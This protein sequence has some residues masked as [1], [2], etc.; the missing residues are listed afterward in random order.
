MDQQ[1]SFG[2]APEST[3]GIYIH[4]P[5]CVHRCSYCAFVSCVGADLQMPYYKALLNE[6]E[7]AGRV[8]AGTVDSV[9]IGGGTPSCAPRGV[10]GGILDALRASFKFSPTAEITLEANPD[11][12]TLDAVAEWRNAD[13]NRLSIGLQSIQA[14]HLF[15]LGRIHTLRD[16]EKAY[17]LAHDS[18]FQ[19]INVDLMYGLP[20]QTAGEWRQTIRYIRSLE[21]EHV[22]CYALSLEEGTSLYEKVMSGALTVPDD[23]LEAKMYTQ[24]AHMLKTAGYNHYEISNFA[25]SGSECR[26]NIK[27]WS[28]DNY[29]GIGAA[30]H[31]L[32]GLLRFANT[33]SVTDY[34]REYENGGLHY[35]G[36]EFV[37]AQERENEFVMLKTRLAEGFTEDEYRYAF[38]RPFR[39]VHAQGLERCLSEGLLEEKNGRI[40]PTQRGFL[41]QN[42]LALNLMTG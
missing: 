7:A 10:V 35:T 39:E 26:H 38:G 28:L 5:F 9:F 31:S 20:S 18:G 1:D 40:Q 27:Y 23:T 4:W 13:V 15:R 6:I 30:A 25:R 34:V 24:A 17:G 36:L 2:G 16:F 22:S 42:Q 41:F 21:P 3:L 8:Y 19:N 29:L 11:S 37:T 14:G 32:I 33:E 12:V